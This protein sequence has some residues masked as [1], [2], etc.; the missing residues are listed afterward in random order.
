MKIYIDGSAKGNPGPGMSIALI[1]KYFTKFL[2]ED[3]IL[4]KTFDNITNNQAEYNSLILALE[5]ID[6]VRRDLKEHKEKE[7]TIIT[8]SKLIV[9]QINDG[10]KVNKNRALV[11]KAKKKINEL[12]KEFD[13]DL[14]WISREQNEAGLMIQHGE[15]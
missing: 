8:D 12:K 6:N 11:L 13:I 15:V 5:Y 4:K 10:W 14:E 3:V 2:D 1:E 7:I 9:G